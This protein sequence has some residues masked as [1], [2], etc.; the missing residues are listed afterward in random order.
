[1]YS[2]KLRNQGAIKI[3]QPARYWGQLAFIYAV[4]QLKIVTNNI[5]NITYLFILN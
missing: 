4:L 5:S 1:M 3:A 2:V